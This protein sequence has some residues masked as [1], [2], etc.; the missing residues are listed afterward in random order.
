MSL[1]S[2]PTTSKVPGLGRPEL[3]D[4]GF[5]EEYLQK[6]TDEDTRLITRWQKILETLLVYVRFLPRNTTPFIAHSN[7]F[8]LGWTLHRRLD[9][10]HHSGVEHVSTKSRG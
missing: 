2:V 10:V 9:S 8:E 1:S 4:R 5:W 6:V 7:N 3:E